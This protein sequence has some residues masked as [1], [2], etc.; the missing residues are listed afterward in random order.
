MA[1]LCKVTGCKRFVFGGGL[2]LG[3][4]HF[5]TDLKER[6]EK[7]KKKAAEMGIHYSVQVPKDQMKLSDL[8]KIADDVFSE[9]KRREH[10][11]FCMCATCGVKAGWKSFDNGHYIPRGNMST[12]FLETNCAPQCQ[13]CNRG[14]DGEEKKMREFLV[15]RY[16]EEE[17]KEVERLKHVRKDWGR[18]ELLDLIKFYRTKIKE[19]G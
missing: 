15:S 8:I 14:N 9:F 19:L 1:R 17:I 3:H 7:A 6:K 2:C 18:D 10:G 12:R 5:R 4:Q 11:D 13:I 16:S